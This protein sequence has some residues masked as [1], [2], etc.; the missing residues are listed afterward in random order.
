MSTETPAC[1]ILKPGVAR[2]DVSSSSEAV[3]PVAVEEPT[4]PKSKVVELAD[5]I[6]W[7]EV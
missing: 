1:G 7:E 3:S 4:K 5:F 2:V 6:D